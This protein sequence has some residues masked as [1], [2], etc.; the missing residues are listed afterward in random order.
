MSSV[1]ISGRVGMGYE[2]LVGRMEY[3][4]I[5]DYDNKRERRDE[6]NGTWHNK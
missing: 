1:F 3:G 4:Y 5:H 6:F 2:V